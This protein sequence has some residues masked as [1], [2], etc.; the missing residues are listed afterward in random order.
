MKKQMFLVATLI[1]G[2]LLLLNQ[3]IASPMDGAVRATTRAIN[4]QVKSSIRPDVKK[5]SKKTHYKTTVNLNMRSKPSSSGS[6]LQTLKKGTSATPTG[7][8]KGVWWEI[9]SVSN[10]GWVHSKYLSQ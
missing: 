9:D 1:S 7:K 8:T 10:V 6:I 4:Q 5:E 2:H 3:S